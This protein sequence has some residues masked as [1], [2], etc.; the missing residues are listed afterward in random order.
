MR[1][2]HRRIT[3]L[4]ALAVV[5]GSTAPASEPQP[6]LGRYKAHVATLASREFSGRQGENA[7]RAGLY[8]ASAFRDLGLE[9]LFGDSYT[10]DIPDP[11]GRGVIGRNIGAK[12]VGSDPALRHEWIIV[13]A[14]F[15][16]LGRRGDTYYPGADDNASGT[17]MLLEVARCFAQADKR[18]R[19][20]VMFVGFDL[21]EY[22]LIG[23]RYFAEHPPVGLDK[24]KLFVTADMLGRSLGGVCPGHVFVFGSDTL[25]GL[26]ENLDATAEREPIELV[27]LGNDLL[28]IDRSDYG[29]FRKRKIPYLFFS[30]GENPAYHQ[31]DDTSDTIDYA[32]ALASTKVILGVLRKTA[33]AESLSGW[34]GASEPN[35]GE[36]LAVRD[37]LK[38]LNAN[39]ETMQIGPAA[40]IVLRTTIATLDGVAARGV[41]TRS[42][43]GRL[44]RAVQFLMATVL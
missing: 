3:V 18:P 5:W 42:E 11:G 14:H 34:I 40:Q 44:V 20:S 35:I 39:R 2:D 7:A 36:A 8:V 41:I 30:T 28:I 4:A 17:A 43:R 25:T 33:D 1:M 27:P 32:T 31:T 26:R 9:P 23:S 37:I 22:G 38:I 29:P 13:G 21:E 10:D 12:L 16:H 24:V 6:Q 15:D 19:R